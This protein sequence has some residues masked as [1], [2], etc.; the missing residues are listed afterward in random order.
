[1]RACQVLGLAYWEGWFTL[2]EVGTAIQLAREKLKCSKRSLWAGVTGPA[3][4]LVATLDRIGWKWIDGDCVADDLRHAWCFG[5]DPPHA[6]VTA[7]RGSVRRWRLDR[8]LKLFSHMAPT[9]SDSH[10]PACDPTLLQDIFGVIAPM[11]RGKASLKN[12]STPWS[13]SW[14]PSL[15]SAVNGGQWPQVRKWKVASWNITDSSCQLCLAATGTIL[16]RFA[17]KATEADRSSKPTPKICRMAEQNL[18]EDRLALLNLRGVAAIKV[19]TLKPRKEDTFE[20]LKNP[21]LGPDADD[22]DDATW[23]TDG[24]PIMGKWASFRCIGFGVVEVSANGK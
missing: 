13:N 7:V 23:Y 8:I 14:A 16:H 12:L 10:A 9:Y 4:A 1:M 5:F 6:F 11:A 19:P 24:S 2:T 22:A 17:C 18:G 21:L 15:V 3:T 20:W